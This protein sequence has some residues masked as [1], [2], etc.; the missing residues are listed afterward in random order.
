MHVPKLLDVLPP[1]PKKKIGD[2]SK[3]G[4]KYTLSLYTSNLNKS[5]RTH[6]FSLFG[7]EG[8]DIQP[9]KRSYI[10]GG[11][12]SLKE[13]RVAE[14]RMQFLDGDEKLRFQC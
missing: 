1:S 6:T 10:C 4:C 13:L 2:L 11:W 12:L 8:V 7:M 5:L 14:T 3:I 9:L